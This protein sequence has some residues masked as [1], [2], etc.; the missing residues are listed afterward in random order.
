MGKPLILIFFLTLPSLLGAQTVLEGD[1]SLSKDFT[2]YLKEGE[3]FP[4][5]PP[6]ECYLTD[7]QQN[8]YRTLLEDVRF[9]YSLMLYGARFVYIPGDTRDQVEDRFEWELMGEIAW[10]DPGLSVT[11]LWFEGNEMYIH[12]RYKLSPTQSAR[13][14][15]WESPVFPVSG[16]WGEYSNYKEN[17]RQEAVRMAVRQS[18]RNYWQPREYERPREISGQVF[19]R[20][21]PRFGVGQGNERAF[22]MT[23]FRFDDIVK[24]PR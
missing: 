7:N 6:P 3:D 20:E 17:A 16:G 15:A 9:L 10:G 8:L 1:F 21:F 13:L 14:E 2:Y 4:L 22:V 12:V 11:D 24:Y 18:V 23:R 5:P 19:L